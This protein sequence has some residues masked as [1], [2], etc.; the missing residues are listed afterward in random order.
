[1]SRS[2]ASLSAFCASLARRSLVPWCTPSSGPVS[3][4]RRCLPA[5]QGHTVDRRHLEASRVGGSF[6]TGLAAR[7]DHML[8]DMAIQ[9]MDNVAIVVDDLDAAVAFFA[10]IGMVLE[11]N[12]QIGSVRADRT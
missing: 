6:R 10:E 4:S 7:R 5:T 8:A 12:G 11:G 9:R 3:A 1:A 2:A